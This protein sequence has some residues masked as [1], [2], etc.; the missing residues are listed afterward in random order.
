MKMLKTFAHIL[1]ALQSRAWLPPALLLLALSSMFLFGND[2]RGYFN[3]GGTH[4]EMSAKN[5]AIAEGLSLDHHFL[6]FTGRTLD[7]DGRHAY[8]VYNRFPIGSYALIKLAICLSETTCLP[9]S[10]QRGR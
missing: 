1:A 4:S 7:T 3:R 8:E 9:K 2:H 10:I 6:M 5:L